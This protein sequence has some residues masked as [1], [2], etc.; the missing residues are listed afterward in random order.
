MEINKYQQPKALSCGNENAFLKNARSLW[1]EKTK[2]K[3]F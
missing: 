3:E 2:I 1:E